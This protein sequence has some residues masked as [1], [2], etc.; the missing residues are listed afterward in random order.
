M[1]E[2]GMFGCLLNHG[3]VQG[4]CNGFL[5]VCCAQPTNFQ[6]VSFEDDTDS[7]SVNDLS[8]DSN[9]ASS[10]RYACLMIWKVCVLWKL[11]KILSILSHKKGSDNFF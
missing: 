10:F 4:T 5:A 9:P 1:A 6:H 3:V 2:L 8:D 11:D 7:S